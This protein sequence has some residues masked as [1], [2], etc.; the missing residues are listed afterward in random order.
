MKGQTL[1][2][3][4]KS[5][6]ETYSYSPEESYFYDKMTQFITDGKAYAAG[7]D[8]QRQRMAILILITMQKLASSS[9]AA[10]SKALSNRLK[11]LKDA[12][13]KITEV[14]NYLKEMKQLQAED[15]SSNFDE[16]SRLEEKI[17]ENI[18]KTIKVNPD[19]IP[20]LEELLRAAEKIDKET[21]IQRI[22]D[23]IDKSFNNRSVLFFTEY[24]ATQALLMSALIERYGEDCVAFING[25]GCIEGVK[26]PSGKVLTFR[27]TRLNAAKKFNFGKVRFLVSTEAAGEGVD[28]QESCH[29]LIHVDLPW[30]PMRLHQ[31]VGRLSRY[32]QKYPVDVVSL[33]NPD[34]VESRI[35]E[36]LDYKLDRITLAFQ[37]AMDDPEDMRDLVIGMASPRMFATI[38]SE[39]DESMKGDK[40]NTWFNSKT[41][42]FGG[43]DAVSVVK[44]IFGNVARF[45][46]GQVA[47]QIPKVDLPDLMPFFK[48][49]FAVFA[50]RPTIVD[51]VRL[52]FKTPKEWLDDFTIAERYN[53]LFDRSSKG[54]EDEDLA[55]VGL[56]V[57]DRAVQTARKM[58]DCLAVV[59]DIKYP[60]IV[61][62]ISDKITDSDSPVKTTVAG[63]E[64]TQDGIWNLLKDW[65]IIKRLNPIADKPRSQALTDSKIVDQDIPALIKEARENLERRVD[66]LE[67]PYHIPVIEGLAC[68]V[69]D[70]K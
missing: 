67:L 57:V 31:R 25:D 35:W 50:K 22:M 69:P 54:L 15:E 45:D 10:V 14:D 23:V 16:I 58:T 63:M 55:G 28:L 5:V 37:G 1:F 46:F 64:H 9:V 32:G 40:L 36:C 34:T 52:S 8:Q 30:N 26:H 43:E 20:A 51:E 61:F 11:K 2:T 53:L 21:K 19:E 29:T 42:T 38:F 70:N 6:Q 27:D 24:K 68:L 7:F 47:H 60:L 33:R 4:V 12:S 13:N 59:S 18:N 66:D 65:E 44:K 41:A 3:P 56:K 17:F 49:L 48:A 39:A 62:G